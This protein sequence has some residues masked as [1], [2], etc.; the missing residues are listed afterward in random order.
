MTCSEY[1]RLSAEVRRHDGVMTSHR[2]ID[3]SNARIAAALHEMECHA[4]KARLRPD[5]LALALATP[6][7]GPRWDYD[8]YVRQLAA[9]HERHEAIMTPIGFNAERVG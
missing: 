7:K 3:Q 4:C 5:A 8:A 9:Q 2:S 6:R 1:E